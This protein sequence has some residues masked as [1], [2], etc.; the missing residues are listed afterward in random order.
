MK[1]PKKRFLE[2]LH[3]KKYEMEQEQ[4]ES[5][6][7]GELAKAVAL[8][9]DLEDEPATKSDTEPREPYQSSPPGISSEKQIENEYKHM[10]SV[11]TQHLKDLVEILKGKKNIAAAFGR[12]SSSDIFDIVKEL[13]S[14]QDLIVSVLGKILRTSESPLEVRSDGHSPY[15][16]FYGKIAKQIAFNGRLSFAIFAHSAAY[17]SCGTSV[18]DYTW[19]RTERGSYPPPFKFAELLQKPL[20]WISQTLENL[21][22]I[23]KYTPADD[24]NYEIVATAEDELFDASGD[25]MPPKQVKEPIKHSLLVELRNPPNGDRKLMSIFLFDNYL[26]CARQ[27]VIILRKHFTQ[28]SDSDTASVSGQAKDLQ[29]LKMNAKSISRYEI[30]WFLPLDRVESLDSNGIA[31]D[32]DKLRERLEKIQSLKEK[33][34]KVQRELH[35]ETSK[36]DK[37]SK[38][39]KLKIPKIHRL[40]SYLY[41]LQAELILQAPRLPLFIGATGGQKYC[42]LMASEKERV[43]WKTAIMEAKNS[44]ILG[45][46]QQDL[47]LVSQ[48]LT[49]LSVK[50]TTTPRS[51]ASNVREVYRS[52]TPNK[53]TAEIDVQAQSDAIKNEL[54][55]I[56]N[57]CKS[58]GPLNKLGKVIISGSALSGILEVCVH[59]INGLVDIAPYYVAI[60]VDFYGQFEQVAKTRCISDTLNPRW[61]QNF[62]IV[63]ET[64]QTICFTV[65]RRSTVIGQLELPVSDLIDQ[66]NASYDV[67]TYEAVPETIKLKISISYTEKQKPYI[68]KL[69]K[70]NSGVYGQALSEVLKRDQANLDELRTLAN[71]KRTNKSGRNH[72]KREEELRV[73]V[74]VTACVE[75]VE[76]RGLQEEGIY[77]ISGAATAISYLQGLFD[78]DVALAIKQIGDYEINVVSGLL[79]L[80]F[81]ELPEPIIPPANLVELITAS[82]ITNENAK[83]KEFNR[84]LKSIPRVNLDTFRY[85]L[86]HLNRVCLHESENKMNLGN[87]SLI[88]GMTLFRPDCTS[89][90]ITLPS[91]SKDPT[92]RAKSPPPSVLSAAS[93][94]MLLNMIFNTIFKAYAEGKLDLSP[95]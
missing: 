28:D 35:E 40:R 67:H 34:T 70:E 11:E 82:A 8:S 47:A 56:I 58:V 27:R 57:H 15:S 73:P 13:H 50:R 95:S 88:W 36:L 90:L 21:K 84:I 1:I 63:L 51:F 43:S 17:K 30:K 62:M 18:G 64:S 3:T 61:D 78:Q 81:R 41:G 19:L 12:H 20:T 22:R 42:L 85:L 9:G 7:R 38:R 60:E 14:T 44:Y 65:F 31:F 76:R 92:D 75:E 86:D 23:R 79:K 72:D 5:D 32:E 10:L 91:D 16:H 29:S 93:N 87:L 59:E 4:S 89:A 80:F 2:R 71:F 55:Y 74:L 37:E 66:A 24:P 6:L 39:Q 53:S 77:R 52:S 25:L 48:S 94:S 54:S 83:M 69:S 45:G 33:I 49:L 26:V 68:R 46:G